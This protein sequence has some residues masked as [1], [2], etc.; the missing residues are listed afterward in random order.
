MGRACR[1]SATDL[2]YSAALQV[3]DGRLIVQGFNRT[4]NILTLK[5]VTSISSQQAI[6]FTKK[7]Q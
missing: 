4:K 5:D 3:I 1:G 7:N 2:V 6:A